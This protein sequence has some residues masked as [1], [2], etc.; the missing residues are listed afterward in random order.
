MNDTGRYP[1]AQHF[2]DQLKRVRDGSETAAAA[3]ISEFGPHVYRVIRR[4]LDM[5]IRSKVDSEDV[6]QLVWA[7]FFRHPDRMKRFQD[8]QDLAHFLAVVARNK[9]IEGVRKY[10][11]TQKYDVSREMSLADSAAPESIMERRI[12]SPS[13]LAIA[14]ERFEQWMSRLSPRH[15]R[16]LG[17]RIAGSNYVQIAT[18]L[19]I[20]ERTV[21]KVISQLGEKA[22]PTHAHGRSRLPVATARWKDTDQEPIL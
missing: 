8:S 18:A 9:A 6:F 15:Q 14:K 16:I 13:Q 21:R 10:R 5:R 22:V 12:K 7:S 17:L 3:L 1:D 20:H 4:R 11:K 2:R 19:G